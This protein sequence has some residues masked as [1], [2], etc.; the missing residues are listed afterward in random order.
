MSAIPEQFLNSRRSRHSVWFA[1]Q[2]INQS[3]IARATDTN[4]SYLCRILSGE[5]QPT[6]PVITKIAKVL[7][8]T[9]DQFLAALDERKAL[10]KRQQQDGVRRALAL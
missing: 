4:P 2:R 7:G 8:M 9:V 1:G 5:R 3:A 6:I 10:L